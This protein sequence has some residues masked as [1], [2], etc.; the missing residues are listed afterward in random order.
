MR[1]TETLKIARSEF[2]KSHP[3]FRFIYGSSQESCFKNARCRALDAEIGDISLEINDIE[4]QIL[5]W[6][7]SK[8]YE[9]A[10][11]LADMNDIC[12]ELDC[13][14]SFAECA[15][16]FNFVQPNLELAETTITSRNLYSSFIDAEDVRHPLVQLNQSKDS[17][18]IPNNIK[19]E[20]T[21]G[22]KIKVGALIIY[23]FYLWVF[24]IVKNIFKDNYRTKCL[25]KD[26]L[27]ETSRPTCLHG[28][29]W[30]VRTGEIV[31]PRQFRSN[32]HVLLHQRMHLVTNELVSSRCQA[33]NRRH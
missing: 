7:Q 29:D 12:S 8:F 19:S 15:L 18:V 13:L 14:M 4:L 17:P 16:E 20:T 22:S 11:M 33:A 24:F 25:G 2:E 23:I 26:D 1:R 21:P 10:Q 27:L 3:E 9:E 30:I 5:E 28:H 32:L 6:L 31:S